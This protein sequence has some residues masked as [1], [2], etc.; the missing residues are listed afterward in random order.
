MRVCGR[1]CGQVCRHVYRHAKHVYRRMCIHFEA[2]QLEFQH[3]HIGECMV[4][5]TDICIQLTCLCIGV[6]IVQRCAYNVYITGHRHVH[7]HVYRN[8]HIHADSR[9]CVRFEKVGR[10]KIKR[11]KRLKAYVQHM[12]MH[13]D[14]IYMPMIGPMPNCV[15]STH[16]STHMP[17]RISEHNRMHISVH[18]FDGAT[19][20]GSI[21]PS[22]PFS[23]SI[24][25][26]ILA[27]GLM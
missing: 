3:L 10:Y 8:V 24:L 4:T 22:T 13:V 18:S 1:V 16:M 7:K 6:Q 15:G 14:Y 2:E 9:P 5:C 11:L 27:Y 21:L 26:I 23:C 25:V 19:F 17:T 12:S 20:I